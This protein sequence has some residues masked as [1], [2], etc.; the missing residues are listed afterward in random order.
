MLTVGFLLPYANPSI[1]S[2]P[3]K[4]STISPSP[5]FYLKFHP[6]GSLF[7]ASPSRSPWGLRPCCR[8]WNGCAL[9]SWMSWPEQ[10]SLDYPST[11]GIWASNQ[12]GYGS[13]EWGRHFSPPALSKVLVPPARLPAFSSF[14]CQLVL[15]VGTNGPGSHSK[16][17]RKWSNLAR[18]VHASSTAVWAHTDPRPIIASSSSVWARTDPNI[19]QKECQIGCQALC[20]VA[21][22]NIG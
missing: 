13:G 4:P 20:H 16:C 6:I 9:S 21:C 22:Q 12:W 15:S 3:A 17:Q 1:T 18:E 11:M 19:H 7:L 5:N 10:S 2:W 8:R 14:F